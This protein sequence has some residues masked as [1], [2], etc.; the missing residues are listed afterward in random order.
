[1]A[2]LSKVGREQGRAF[3]EGPNPP[4]RERKQG[5]QAHHEARN[6]HD[7]SRTGRRPRTR[8]D[9]PAST[10]TTTAAGTRATA[11]QP[12]SGARHGGA[13]A[14]G[15]L[16]S[17]EAAPHRFSRKPDTGS[18]RVRSAT[19]ISQSWSI[20]LASRQSCRRS[21]NWLRRSLHRSSRGAG[22]TAPLAF[23]TPQFLP[24]RFWAQFVGI[25]AGSSGVPTSGSSSVLTGPVNVRLAP[26]SQAIQTP[27]ARAMVTSGA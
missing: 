25:S 24:N 13:G 26:A 6:L 15:G 3:K 1:M 8:P 23:E 27:S 17:S 11:S 16:G 10:T 20:S 12:A 7:Q 19:C 18:D 14:G 5:R 22:D 4:R 2:A 21:Q 9:G